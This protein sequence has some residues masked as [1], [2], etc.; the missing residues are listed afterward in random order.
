MAIDPIR[1]P[2]PSRGA[3]KLFR[4]NCCKSS[5]AKPT[6]PTW[7]FLRGV[8][9]WFLA[10]LVFVLVMT[11]FNRSRLASD[12]EGGGLSSLF[13]ILLFFG[14]IVA[15]VAYVFSSVLSSPRCPDCKSTNFAK[16]D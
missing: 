6:N 16:P 7:D 9:C 4:C 13:L 8:S 3:A 11:A 5:F 12:Y 14:L 10:L 2:T 1:T 15:G